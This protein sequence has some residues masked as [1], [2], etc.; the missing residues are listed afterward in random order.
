MPDAEEVDKGSFG[1]RQLVGLWREV[2]DPSAVTVVVGAGRTRRRRDS[3]I[4][5][6]RSPDVPARETGRVVQ[7]RE[8]LNTN[9]QG[10]G[11]PP[12][13]SV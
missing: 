11:S 10:K 7:Q 2:Q 13:V 12:G 4:V 1:W 8:V 9:R 5:R 3:G 6:G